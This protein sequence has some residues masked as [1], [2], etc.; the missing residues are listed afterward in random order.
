MAPS[1]TSELLPTTIVP[2][3]SNDLTQAPSLSPLPSSS[4]PLPSSA[5]PVLPDEPRLKFKSINLMQSPIPKGSPDKLW[6]FIKS[7]SMGSIEQTPVKILL[8]KETGILSAVDQIHALLEYKGEYYLM[9]SIAYTMDDFESWIF[10]KEYPKNASTIYLQ[11]AFG[12][13]AS[14]IFY[15]FYDKESQKWFS[16]QEFGSPTVIDLDHDGIDEIVIEFMGKPLNPTDVKI[17]K[18][19]RIDLNFGITSVSQTIANEVSFQPMQH[20]L[21]VTKKISNHQTVFNVDFSSRINGTG[22]SA[23]YG[24]EKGQLRKVAAAI[25]DAA[26]FDRR[27]I[28]FSYSNLVFFDPRDYRHVSTG[29]YLLSD[30]GGD[31]DHP[32]AMFSNIFLV[33]D[34]LVSTTN[35]QIVKPLYNSDYVEEMRKS[36][37]RVDRSLI[38]AQNP[39]PIHQGSQIVFLTNKDTVE[40]SPN[41]MDIHRINL[42]G[43]GEIRLM[44]SSNPIRLLDTANNI[45]VAV[46]TDINSGENTLYFIHSESGEVEKINIKTLQPDALSSDGSSVLLRTQPYSLS[47][48]ILVLNIASKKQKVIGKVTDS[49]FFYMDQLEG[50]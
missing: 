3:I 18:W 13:A 28:R 37:N 27:K 7:I 32:I 21:S 43:S 22:S 48:D 46:S 12:S 9:S 29:D 40:K 16:Y 19:N 44:E 35:L 10:Q 14:G 23:I 30:P 36:I 8:Y 17:L 20:V 26:V 11:G 39:L 5:L 33:N 6:K 15:V 47:S 34:S 38:W 42:D 49:Y 24:Y 4:S 25:F 1:N 45:L 2:I 50:L 41:Q 31:V